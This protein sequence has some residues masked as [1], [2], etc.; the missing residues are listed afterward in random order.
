MTGFDGHQQ[1]KRRRIWKISLAMTKII[2]T[3]MACAQQDPTVQLG[4]RCFQGKPESSQILGF[5]PW[6]LEWYNDVRSGVLWWSTFD[7]GCNWWDDLNSSDW[8]AVEKKTPLEGEFAWI[9][10]KPSSCRYHDSTNHMF[11]L[12]TSRCGENHFGWCESHCRC[13]ARLWYQTG[14]S[15]PKR[16]RALPSSWTAAGGSCVPSSSPSYGCSIEVQ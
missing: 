6:I 4:T 15:L 5:S 14:L 16:P 1:K 10:Q 12:V 9:W 8:W 11:V 7:E 3:S 13:G 2:K